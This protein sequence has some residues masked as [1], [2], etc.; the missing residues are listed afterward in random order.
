MPKTKKKYKQL[1]SCLKNIEHKHASPSLCDEESETLDCEFDNIHSEEYNAYIT[2]NMQ[3][4]KMK[5]KIAYDEYDYA[6]NNIQN[7][8]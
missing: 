4:C 6:L 2:L 7:Y 3:G 5:S 8:V 1:K